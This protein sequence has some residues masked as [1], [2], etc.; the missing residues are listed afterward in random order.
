MQSHVSGRGHH[1]ARR[2]RG[3]TA[4]EECRERQ[5]WRRRW[6]GCPTGEGASCWGA[7]LQ[8][9]RS[10]TSGLRNCKRIHFS[11]SEPL[12]SCKVVAAIWSDARTCYRNVV[13]FSLSSLCSRGE[14]SSVPFGSGQCVAGQGEKT[15]FWVGS[16]WGGE[17]VWSSVFNGSAA[18]VGVRIPRA[19]GCLVRDWRTRP[20]SHVLY[21]GLG[22]EEAMDGFHFFPTKVWKCFKAGNKNTW[23]LLHP[24]PPPTPNHSVSRDLPRTGLGVPGCPRRGHRCAGVRQGAFP[25]LQSPVVDELGPHCSEVSADTLWFTSGSAN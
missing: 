12:T 23:A 2:R 15:G 8:T 25:A 21:V 24:R 5:G 16:V 11:H 4:T 20:L 3:A 14:K 6:P 19:A 10:G 22:V 9:P 7:A 13:S 17:L 18:Q 1:S